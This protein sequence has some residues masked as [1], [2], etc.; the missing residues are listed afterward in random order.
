MI[1]KIVSAV[2]RLL[3]ALLFRVGAVFVQ[4]LTFTSQPER[5]SFGDPELFYNCTTAGHWGSFL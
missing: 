5:L 3:Q 4:G 2:A 1:G